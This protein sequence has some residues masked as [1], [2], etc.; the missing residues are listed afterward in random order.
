MKKKYLSLSLILLMMFSC[1]NRNNNSSVIIFSDQ[2]STIN[3]SLESSNDV[4]S[5][6]ESSSSIEIN[7]DISTY[8]GGYYSSI[9]SWNDSNDLKNQLHDLIKD[10]IEL[11]YNSNWATNKNADR[12]LS[13]FDMVNQVYSP[14]DILKDF[15][16]SSFN[17]GGW[18]REH[19]FCQSL[20]NHYVTKDDPVACDF[21]NLFAA[22][23]TG[24]TSRGN[25]YIGKVNSPNP[26]TSIEGA[27]YS[28]KITFEPS[29][30]DK[31]RLSRALLYMD[32]RYDDLSL[33]DISS[34]NGE[35]ITL[36]KGQHP[37]KNTI[38]SWA[39]SYQVDYL[40]YQHNSQVFLQQNNRNP[41]SDFPKLVD[42]VY[43]D[44]K[45]QAGTINDLFDTSTQV[46]LK[47]NEDEF[48]NLA[49]ENINY[50]YQVGEKFSL[51]QSSFYE[52]YTSLKNQKIDNN[53]ILSSLEEGYEFTNEDIGEKNI[54]VSYL[55]SSC[56]FKIKVKE[57]S[58]VEDFEY[59]YSF[60]D[61]K[62][63]VIKDPY[64]NISSTKPIETS[65][66][67]IDF[68]FSIEDG[69]RGTSNAN[70]GLAFG[71]KAKP[72]KTLG[73]ESKNEVE[74]INKNGMNKFYIVISNAKDCSCDINLYVNDVLLETK[75]SNNTNPE[76]F[77]FS[78]NENLK[79]KI[80]FEIK[81]IVGTVYI[82]ELGIKFA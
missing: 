13:N 75:K 78:S 55:N 67:G 38:V 77:I 48:L 24:N 42:Y 44:K 29:D 31:G 28:D 52:V 36:E 25:K 71:T 15:T 50:E 33:V 56:S 17:V 72:V 30:E 53:L 64:K 49:I 62:G 47:T 7:Q 70:K 69:S 10:N 45:D 22:Y 39:S 9:K 27:Y 46:L 32:T 61:E 65:L 79:G 12:S 66:N 76:Y 23:Y 51:S 2:E 73:I 37:N 43:G 19:V 35:E 68:I 14:N 41:Y 3:S 54:T 16:N 18:Q 11:K 4:S 6:E 8:Y 1:S 74:F 82:K 81:N 26:S 5:S 21:H 34:E 20:M 60:V 80:K 58:L 59:K 63:E 57:K 40:E